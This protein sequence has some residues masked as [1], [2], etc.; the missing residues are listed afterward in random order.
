MA[1]NDSN[2]KVILADSWRDEA[3]ECIN[4]DEVVLGSMSAARTATAH[5]TS[6]IVHNARTRMVWKLRRHI[7]TA[8]EGF[9]GWC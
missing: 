7:L 3:E 9:C 2:R 6:V 1:I 4:D 5:D 8:A